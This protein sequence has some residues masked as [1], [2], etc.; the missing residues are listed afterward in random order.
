M[1]NRNVSSMNKQRNHA[2]REGAHDTVGLTSM[3]EYI[4]LNGV[5]CRIRKDFAS[6]AQTPWARGAG[7]VPRVDAGRQ[8]PELA[9]EGE[10]SRTRYPSA[11]DLS[12]VRHDARL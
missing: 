9:H 2:G 6:G 12:G 7:L 3:R 8:A 5:G 10:A 1:G 11:G 4:R